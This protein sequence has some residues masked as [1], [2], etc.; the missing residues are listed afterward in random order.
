MQLSG[1]AFFVLVVAF[2]SLTL[3]VAPPPVP[4]VNVDSTCIS[5]KGDPHFTGFL[6]Q[7]FDFQGEPDQNFHIYSDPSCSINAHFHKY[8]LTSTT[9]DAVALRVGKDVIVRFH[10]ASVNQ[11][12]KSASIVASLPA[13]HFDPAAS[14]SESELQ[15]KEYTF[16]TGT[17]HVTECG[18]FTWKFPTFTVIFND[19]TLQLDFATDQTPNHVLVEYFNLNFIPP[20]S[21]RAP[22]AKNGGIL[23]VTNHPGTPKLW[24][25]WYR[26]P[27]GEDLSSLRAPNTF[28]H[29]DRADSF[30]SQNSSSSECLVGAFTQKKRSAKRVLGDYPVADVDC[31]LCS[32]DTKL[33]C[34]CATD[35]QPASE[36]CGDQC[37]I[38]DLTGDPAACFLCGG[39]FPEDSTV[40]TPSGSKRMAELDAGDYVLDGSGSFTPVLMFL[41]RGQSSELPYVRV[42]YRTNDNSTSALELSPTHSLAIES[43]AGKVTFTEAKTV[44]VGQRVF[45]H[46]SHSFSLGA[47]Q[48]VEVE[49]VKR[50]GA[51]VP[52]TLSGTLMVDGAFV[53]SFAGV[54]HDIGMIVSAP[55]RWISHLFL[56]TSIFKHQ[57]QSYFNMIARIFAFVFG[58]LV[59]IPPLRLTPI[60]REAGM[61]SY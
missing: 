39:C 7:K 30:L 11:T 57:G 29:P 31:N 58:K 9:V 33:A 46:Q 10:A 5:M 49:N 16:P 55:L 48:I 45:I 8:T 42:V 15:T 17:A 28:F 25:S 51:Y 23:G 56:P 1:V 19:Y 27:Q 12:S 38:C 53:S 54:P 13:R 14:S 52:L 2:V 20:A 26:L 22:D 41:E 3:A 6:G 24:P 60:G 34:Q 43:E 32:T 35:T 18:L 44:G 50:R 36:C 37:C 47:V 4:T 61:T 21:R 59:N 40:V